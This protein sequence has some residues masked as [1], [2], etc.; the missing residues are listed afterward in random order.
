MD[1]EM[2]RRRNGGE[3]RV[4]GRGQRTEDKGEKV[5]K[6]KS[7]ATTRYRFGNR[8][9]S[10]YAMLAAAPRESARGRRRRGTGALTLYI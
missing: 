6:V 8:S 9:A 3:R 2:G 5:A 1:R 10:V 7:G 4:E